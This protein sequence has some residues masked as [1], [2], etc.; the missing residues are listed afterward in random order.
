MIQA[1]KHFMRVAGGGGHSDLGARAEA[2]AKRFVAETRG[3]PR[4][5]LI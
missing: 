2:A 4:I 5:C 1:P 3:R